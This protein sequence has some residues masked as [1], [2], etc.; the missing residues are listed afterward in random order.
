MYYKRIWHSLAEDTGGSGP[1]GDWV[2][3]D[4]SVDGSWYGK[5]DFGV[6]VVGLVE[7]VDA[8]DHIQHS[9][10]ALVSI[11]TLPEWE[12]YYIRQRSRLK[13]GFVIK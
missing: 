11:E 9:C 7:P 6:S 13:R 10:Q 12:Q 5:T 8:P 2:N 3:W 4:V 1:T